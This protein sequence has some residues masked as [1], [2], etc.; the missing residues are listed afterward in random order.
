MSRYI[1]PAAVQREQLMQTIRIV[2]GLKMGTYTR[3]KNEQGQ[4][5]TVKSDRLAKYLQEEAAQK[6]TAITQAEY[7]SILSSPKTGPANE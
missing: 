2:Q 3:F 7:E 4:V 5:G 1:P 6:L